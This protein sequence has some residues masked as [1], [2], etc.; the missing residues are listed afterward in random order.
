V[1]KRKG[2]GAFYSYNTDKNTT[3][4]LTARSVNAIM[5]A[6][7]RRLL[8]SRPTKLIAL[9]CAVSVS[10]FFVYRL[11]LPPRRCLSARAP[12]VGVFDLRSVSGFN[13][14]AICGGRVWEPAVVGR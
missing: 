6:T 8:K 12:G 9:C 2:A 5:R 14:D 1:C 7:L 4:A 11:A 13:V 10:V 3:T